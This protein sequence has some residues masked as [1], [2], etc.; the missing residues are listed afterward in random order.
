ML[1]RINSFMMAL[2][3]ITLAIALFAVVNTMMAS[4]HE[5]IKD[6]GIMRA[7]GASRPGN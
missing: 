2:A 6:I 7:V 3:G 1:Q 5:R 4:V